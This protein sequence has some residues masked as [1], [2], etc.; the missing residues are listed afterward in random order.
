MA[1]AVNR[2]SFRPTVK[3]WVHEELFEG[4]RLSELINKKQEN[5]KY[6]PGIKLPENIVAH[7]NIQV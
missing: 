4:R 1:E 2:E 7:S 3:M 6:L 5:V